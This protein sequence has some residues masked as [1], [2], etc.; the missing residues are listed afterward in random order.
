MKNKIVLPAFL[1]MVLVQ[2]YVPAKMIFNK[3][4]VV[5][6]GKEFRFKTAPVDPT[7][8]FRG[9]YIVLS[10]E[11]NAIQVTNADDW[12]QGD[13]I[14]VSL[15]TDEKGY[16]RI[17]S[18]SKEE[19]MNEEDYVKANIGFIMSD[20]L[21]NVNILYPFDR[22]YMEETKAYNAEQA[23]NE[24]TRDTSQVTYALVKVK[25]GDAVVTDVMINGI[26]IRQVAKNWEDNKLFD[27]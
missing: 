16:A 20:S 2:L 8:P 14:F 5:T 9:K 10:F 13:P 4:N 25:K 23:Y 12:N 26:P 18:V 7:D 1:I 11:E 17:L 22:F 15:T 6:T 24:S 21:S 3:E 19:P 27:N